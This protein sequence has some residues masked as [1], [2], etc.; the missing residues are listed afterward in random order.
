MNRSSTS[1]V[2]SA[3]RA[4]DVSTW[5]DLGLYLD[6][7]RE[8][9]GLPG[10]RAPA[11]FDEFADG[12]ARG[13]AFITFEFAVDGVTVEAEKYAQAFRKLIP[14]VRMHYVAGHFA[15]LADHVI[16][17]DAEWHCMEEL[18]A[19][20]NW[21]LYRDFFQRKLERG[22]PLY[23]QL[24]TRFWD[25]TLEIIERLC[26]IVLENDIQLFY[27]I[28]V[29]SNPGNVAL[30]LAVAILSEMLE[31][32]V[33]S[34]AHDFYWE[35][36]ASA[37]EREQ[38]QLARGPRDHFFTNS[39][40]GEIF[41]II[42]L[43]YPWESRLWVSV[44][45]NHAQSDALCERFG[46]CPAGVSEIGTAIDEERFAPQE[47]H[48]IKESWRQLEEIFS[49]S[50][51]RVQ[52]SPAREL[53]GSGGAEIQKKPRLIAR[54]RQNRVELASNNILLLQPTR[55][56]GRKKIEV[57]LRIIADLFKNGEFA[58]AFRAD[59]SLKLTLLVTGPVAVGHDSYLE[60]IIR[61]FEALLGDLPADVR[62]RVYLAL[63]FSAFDDS[64]FRARHEHPLGM[65]EL[66]NL[67]SLVV[68]PSQTEGRGL[69]IIESAACGAPILSRR[70]EPQEV[71]DALIG[72]DLPADDRL[73]IDSFTGARPDA[74][75]IEQLAQK[76]ISPVSRTSVSQHNRGVI[77]RRFS[78]PVLTA[79][80]QS[81]LEG[82]HGRLQSAEPDGKLAARA[83]ASFDDRLR[84]RAPEFEDLVSTSQRE[85]LAGFGRMGF[86]LMLKSLIDPSYF[87]IEEQRLRSM[88]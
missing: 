71:F 40:V 85:Y 69:P 86:M 34:N 58:A 81:I 5:F 1:E 23:N 18:Q 50:R 45:I 76:L 64:A 37:V 55:I 27:L 3:L 77:E 28:N 12:L 4:E 43:L 42:E 82:L 35:G 47:R 67:A 21:P 66:Y 6:R 48:V 26:D 60:R 24:I 17:T 57:N 32:P 13:V 8:G 2:L 61:D 7:L 20:D 80:L 15:E 74:R 65:P 79:D 16:G 87:R 53:L 14:D 56:I 73:Q 46:V 59:E 52:A 54:T 49:G 68:L 72:A 83:F 10:P 44:C 22:G 78:M 25:A 88:A 39:T 70:Y 75:V 84:S 36:G 19:F 30:A 11:S 41:S 62:D 38:K 63:L 9:R 29:S 51:T 31:I 33:V